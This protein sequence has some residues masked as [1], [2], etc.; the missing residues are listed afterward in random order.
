[1]VDNSSLDR[2][3]CGALGRRDD[4]DGFVTSFRDRDLWICVGGTGA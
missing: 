1:M 2:E 4:P 3:V